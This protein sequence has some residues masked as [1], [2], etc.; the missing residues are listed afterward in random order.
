MSKNKIQIS[1]NKQ[2]T[3]TKIQNSNPYDLEELCFAHFIGRTAPAYAGPNNWF[4]I[5][6]ESWIL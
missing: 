5:L 2:I 4:W 1:N 3:I 6:S